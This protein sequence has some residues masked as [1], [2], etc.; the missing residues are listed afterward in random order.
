MK[1]K[2]KNIPMWLIATVVTLLLLIVFIN[3]ANSSLGRYTSSFFQEVRFA[4]KSAYHL[5]LGE[6]WN[7]AEQANETSLSVSVTKAETELQ[8]V[9]VGVRVYIPN[10][11]GTLPD[12]VLES[13]GTEYEASAEEIR[14]DTAAYKIYGAGKICRFYSAQGSELCFAV[15]DNVGESLEMTLILASSEIDTNGVQ[16]IVEPVNTEKGGGRL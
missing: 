9:S 4:P 6:E 12:L 8:S 1:T 13:D 11:N 14:P 16:V 5:T 3:V 7:V 15:P 2:A 10:L